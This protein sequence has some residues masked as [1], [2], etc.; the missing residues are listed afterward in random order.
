M[1][2]EQQAR[3][4][5]FGGDGPWSRATGVVAGTCAWA[6]AILLALVLV[7]A[8]VGLLVT[9]VLGARGDE[10]VSWATAAGAVGLIMWMVAA[11]VVWVV[12]LP[13][14]IVLER[15]L[16]DAA[17]A[18]PWRAAVLAGLGGFLAFAASIV[19]GL[20]AWPGML[21]VLVVAGLVAAGAGR[22]AVAR[23]ARRVSEGRAMLPG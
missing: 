5:R 7:A 21:A 9:A 6:S 12:G 15:V 13:V 17:V 20:W 19:V 8:V 10:G 16:D 2:G 11:V 22:L 4:W 14:G 1:T 18:P 23:R 3:V